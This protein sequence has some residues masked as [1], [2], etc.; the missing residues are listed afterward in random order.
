M[1]TDTAL[2]MPTYFLSHGGGPWPWLS[3]PMR[4]TMAQLEESL[5][6]LP[7]DLPAAPKAILMISGHWETP[8]FTVQTNPNPPMVYD[9]GGFPEH[10]YQ[11]QYPA[12]GSP[13]LA[14]RVVEL[15][16]A[17]GID[18]AEDAERG[19][20]HG[21]FAPMAASW[22]DADVPVVQLSVKH[23]YDPQEHLAVGRALAPLRDE[24]ILI[25]GSGL[26]YHN[27][28]MM[29]PEAAVPSREFD[30]WLH[31]TMAIADP[32]ERAARLS[33]WE[34]APSARIAHPHADHLIPLMVVAGASEGDTATRTYH[35]T[36]FFGSVSASSFRFDRP[37]T[38]STTH[39]IDAPAYA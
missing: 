31:E 21:M 13:A 12:P 30:D 36:D 27:L 37:A 8:V 4:D 5:Q 25:L 34:H 1:T 23:G 9:Y 22:P 38:P 10:T 24:G 32:A 11:I 28:R 6:R 17:A 19:Y 3:G 35:Q 16:R 2:T 39:A 33:N 7:G 29:G 20:D 14:A 26:S 18:I 15:L